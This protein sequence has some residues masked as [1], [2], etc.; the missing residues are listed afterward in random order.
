LLDENLV[1]KQEPASQ[2]FG[3]HKEDNLNPERGVY[4]LI[5]AA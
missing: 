2:L 3:L 5:E 1:F 4:F